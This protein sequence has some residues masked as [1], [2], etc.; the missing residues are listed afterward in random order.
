M[1]ELYAE[2]GG[3]METLVRLRSGDFT[4]AQ[5]HRIEEILS[6]TPE[7]FEEKLITI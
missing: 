3:C 5:S 7:E 6:W 4:I 2:A 1:S